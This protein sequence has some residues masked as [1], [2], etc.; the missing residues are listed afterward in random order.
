MSVSAETKAKTVIK[1]VSLPSDLVDG[2][3]AV[4]KE[5]HRSFSS[6]VAKLIADDLKT[7][8]TEQAA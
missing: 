6:Y 7:K 5:D 1:T 8:G 2:A 3:E 4:A